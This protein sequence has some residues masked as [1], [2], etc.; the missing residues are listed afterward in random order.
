MSLPPARGARAP[1]RWALGALAPLLALSTLGGCGDALGPA[2]F[3]DTGLPRVRVLLGRPR[4]LGRVAVSGQGWEVRAEAGAAFEARDVKPLLA[5]FSVGSRGIR[6]WGR[7]TGAERL[8]LR[9]PVAFDLD[10]RTYEGDLIVRLAE[11]RLEFVNELDLETYVAGVLANEV[12]PLG[13]P[14]MF[15]AQA[16]AARTYAWTRISARDARDQAWHVYDDARSQVY[17]GRTMPS[18]TDL[19]YEDMRRAARQTE[20]V[21]LTFQGRPFVAYYASTCG[22]HTTDAGTSRLDPGTARDVLQGVPCDHCRTSRYF[23][24]TEEV[25]EEALIEALK[26][27]GRPVAPPLREVRVSAR[28][29]GGWAAEVEV[30]AGPN[31]TVKKVP[32]PAF[33]TAAG[34]R[35]HNIDAISRAGPGRWRV[36]GRGWGHG[37]GMC[38]WGALEMARKGARETDILAYYYPGSALHKLY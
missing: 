18:G 7:D 27:D 33:R 29:R 32:G 34:L 15:R 9:A 28:G 20:G 5:S 26:R 21:V 25:A 38:Q 17:A 2:L 12:G 24:W 3:A 37:V 1:A 4:A 13:V 16:V 22:G 14:S 19:R 31:A 35:S 36:R 11:G 6:F 30:V 10:G 8:R 23:E